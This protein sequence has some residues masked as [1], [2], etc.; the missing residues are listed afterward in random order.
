MC[1]KQQGRGDRSGSPLLLHHLSVV[2]LKDRFYGLKRGAAPGE[3]G[4]RWKEYE[5]GLEDRLVDLHR[6]VHR[7]VYRAQPSRN[8]HLFERK[9][10]G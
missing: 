2:L 9:I 3:D 4:V 6:R 7:G 10:L 5:T 1:G 8:Y